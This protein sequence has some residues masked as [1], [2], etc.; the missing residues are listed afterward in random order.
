M[1]CKLN[2]FFGL[3]LITIFLFASTTFAQTPIGNYRS[4]FQ[5]QGNEISFSASNADVRI[6]FCTPTMFRVQVSWK[7]SFPNN[8]NLMVTKYHWPEVTYQASDQGDHF[9]LQTEKLKVIV[10]KNP[11]RISVETPDGTIISSESG[12]GFGA[13]KDSGAVVCSKKL[14]PGEH[15]FGFGERMGFTDQLGKDVHLNVGRGIAHS[16]IMGAYNVMK[17]NYSPVPFFMSTRGYGIFLHNSYATD[18]DMGHSNPD[19]YTFKADGGEMDYYFIYGP[20]FPA[21]LNQYT[22]LTGKSPMMSRFAYG[23]HVGTYSGGTWGHEQDASPEYVINLGHK[24]RNE[25]VP[26]DI[27]WLDS[28]WRYFGKIGHGGTSFQWRAVF[29]HPEAMLDSLYKMHYAMVGLHIRPFL[30]NGTKF[31]LLTDARKQGGVLYPANG[32]LGDIVNFFNPSSV[33]WWWKHGVMKVASVGVKFVKTDAG[34][35]FVYHSFGSHANPSVAQKVDSLHN[36]FPI[37]YARGPYEEFM[38]YNKMRGMNQTREGY[39]GIQRYPYIFAGDWPSRWQYFGPIIKAGLNIGLS[40]V[41]Y[42][43]NCN[44]GFEQKA[45]PELYIRWT[46]FG[47]LSPVAMIFGMDH[48]GYKEPWNYGKEALKIFRQYDKLRYSLIPYIYTSAYENH[49]TGVPLMRALVLEYQND[50]NTYDVADEYLFGDDML[51]CP[52]TTKGANSRVVY[53][54]KGTWYNYWTGEKVDGKQDITVPTPLDQMPIFIKAGAIIPMQK[55]MK[56]VGQEPVDTLRLDIY[57]FK[58]SSYSIYDDDGK[59]LK[60]ETGD[61]AKTKIKCRDDESRIEVAINTPVGKY[62]VPARSYKLTVHTD[63]SPI[64]VSANGSQLRKVQGL[65]EYK[66]SAHS[67]VWYYNKDKNL[68]YVRPGGNSN[69]EINVEVQKQ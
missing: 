24:F 13:S 52:V 12:S 62:N 16:H 15:F 26:A 38:K 17:A 47:M 29:K 69:S 65:K 27:L 6:D 23:L 28:T 32:R 40:G 57:P 54:P 56:Y 8:E 49:T 68:L 59:S 25:D 22:D 41:G 10:T 67:Q 7:R 43:A 18:W 51:V 5:K 19:S 11:V 45:D 58:S 42:W 2:Q 9:L 66:N 4:G 37:A 34:N 35:S 1:K 60:Y 61:F 64:S 53:L 20:G 44:G 30:D 55:P 63:H 31:H 33:D 3:L 36:L 48:P 46:Q 50:V 21:I 39:A 14:I